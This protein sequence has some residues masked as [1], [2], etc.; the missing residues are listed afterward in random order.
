M[1]DTC[2]VWI[3]DMFV[4]VSIKLWRFCGV[5]T[6]DAQ[7]RLLIIVLSGV[8][9]FLHVKD[10]NPFTPSDLHG[11]GTFSMTR[12]SRHRAFGE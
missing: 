10:I 8:R 2:V 7:L 9:S 5:S 6:S 11:I 1:I 4:R 12:Q 3:K